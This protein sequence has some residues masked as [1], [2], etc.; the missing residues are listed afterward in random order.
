MKGS[1]LK[2]ANDAKEDQQTS[3]QTPK[4]ANKVGEKTVNKTDCKKVNTLKHIRSQWE[5]VMLDIFTIM[6]WVMF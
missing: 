4:M 2:D 3:K 5:K 1:R 6:D